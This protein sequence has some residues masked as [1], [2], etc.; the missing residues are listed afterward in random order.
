MEKSSIDVVFERRH[1]EKGTKRRCNI[2]T[3]NITLHP[4]SEL[5]HMGSPNMVFAIAKTQEDKYISMF[6]NVDLL[7]S[8]QGDVVDGKT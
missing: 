8:T 3:I 1:E 5:R 6:S 4:G 2:G 7:W